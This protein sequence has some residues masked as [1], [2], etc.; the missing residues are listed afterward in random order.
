MAVKVLCGDK[1]GI[2]LHM[3]FPF[4]LKHHCKNQDILILKNI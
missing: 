2:Y 4:S 3:L 1:I